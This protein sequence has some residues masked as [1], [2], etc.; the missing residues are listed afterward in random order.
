MLVQRAV[1]DS[2]R[3]HSRP[4]RSDERCSHSRRD[5]RE[6]YRHAMLVN[7]ADWM[8]ISVLLLRDV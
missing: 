3:S 4:S 7:T 6:D 8:Q 2:G 5:G 1:R